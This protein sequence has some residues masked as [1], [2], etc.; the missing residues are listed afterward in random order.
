MPDAQ[1]K[2]SR[3]TERPGLH[4]WLIV[5]SSVDL[6]S[7]QFVSRRRG[8]CTLPPAET[9]QFSEIFYRNPSGKNTRLKSRRSFDGDVCV[10]SVLSGTTAPAEHCILN[11]SF[12]SSYS[13]KN[14]PP[15]KI[16]HVT[17]FISKPIDKSAR[18]DVLKETSTASHISAEMNRNFFLS[19]IN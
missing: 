7:G 12:V 3:F 17:Y 5:L 1:S 2:A 9:C 13:S 8:T 14:S 10:A 15:Q 6:I 4:V 16:V 11:N 19:Q 18:S